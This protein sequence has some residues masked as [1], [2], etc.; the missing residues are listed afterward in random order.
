M[1][2]DTI[3]KYKTEHT[4]KKNQSHELYD[5]FVLNTLILISYFSFSILQT[6]FV[7]TENHQ[8]VV[9]EV[10]HNRSDSDLLAYKRIQIKKW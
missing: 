8:Q 7:F 1:F 4:G 2:S 6:L 3:I 10:G 5:S 9:A